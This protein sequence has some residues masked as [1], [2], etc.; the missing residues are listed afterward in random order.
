MV[1]KWA[2]D[3]AEALK[4]LHGMTPKIVHR[5]LKPCNVLLD[6]TLTCKISDL[7]LCKAI[8]REFL[9]SRAGNSSDINKGLVGGYM[10][11]GHVG[12]YGYMAPEVGPDSVDSDG[13]CRYNELCDIFSYGMVVHFM[14]TGD[15][16]FPWL[17]CMV[18]F[19]KIKKGARP[20]LEDLKMRYPD[21][22]CNLLTKCLFQNPADRPTAAEVV[23]YMKVNTSRSRQGIIGIISGVHHTLS[24]R[25][26]PR[27][28][29][30]ESVSPV[31]R[32]ESK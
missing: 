11:S 10:M 30:R 26:L 20:D 7:G 29:S 16:P 1:S 6:H 31:S 17:R 3:I 9:K 18:A 21:W 5:D 8:D 22:T 23:E 15:R 27:A 4:F 14:C 24:A 25:R 2:L 13:L 28:S 32:T 12:T 19:E